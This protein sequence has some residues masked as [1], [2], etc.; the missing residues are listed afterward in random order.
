[1]AFKRSSKIPRISDLEDEHTKPTARA[2]L[3]YVS[4]ISGKISRVLKRFNIDTTHRPMTNL[5]DRLVRAKDPVGLM[6]PGVYKIPC[7]CGE[8][9]VGET[10]RTISTRLKEH[11]RHFRLGQPEKSAVVEHS[12]NLDH[13]IMWDDTRVLWRSGH[14]WDRLTKEAIEIRMERRS[15]NRDSGYT[16]SGSWNRIL[17]RI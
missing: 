3:P 6:T 7:E 1:M 11:R 8:V 9:Y 15:L 5:R 14:F 2:V 16:I 12:L 4:T 17:K 13:R 10:G